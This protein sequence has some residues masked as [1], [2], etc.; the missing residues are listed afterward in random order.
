LGAAIFSSQGWRSFS[1]FTTSG[2]TDGRKLI[3]VRQH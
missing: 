2:S 1:V 3:G